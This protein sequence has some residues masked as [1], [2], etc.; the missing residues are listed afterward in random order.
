MAIVD[1]NR[2][3]SPDVGITQRG[4]DNPKINSI[5]FQVV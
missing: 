4:M 1:V 2:K 3:F 5:F